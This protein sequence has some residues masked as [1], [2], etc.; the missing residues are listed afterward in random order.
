MDRPELGR[1]VLCGFGCYHDRLG[2]DTHKYN[3]HKPD[4]NAH[5]DRDTDSYTDFNMQSYG[6]AVKYFDKHGYGNSDKNSHAYTDGYAYKYYHE[7]FDSYKRAER[8][9]YRNRHGDKNSHAYN[10]HYEHIDSYKRAERDF[11]SHA[12]NKPERDRDIFAD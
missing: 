2:P 4:N 10:C 3:R 5:Q 9:F 1:L 11:Y 7:H 8:D 12:D 6:H